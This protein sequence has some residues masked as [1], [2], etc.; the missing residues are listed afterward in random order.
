MEE[1]NL[2]QG[3]EVKI[4]IIPFSQVFLLGKSNS[5]H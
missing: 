1:P 5:F 2:R 4:S 3:L